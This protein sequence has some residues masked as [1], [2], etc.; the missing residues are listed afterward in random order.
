MQNYC[1]RQNGD[2]STYLRGYAADILTRPILEGKSMK[3]NSQTFQ[4]PVFNK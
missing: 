3:E 1:S 4:I 2:K